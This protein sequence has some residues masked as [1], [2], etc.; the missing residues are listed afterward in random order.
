[1]KNMKGQS[2]ALQIET[3]FLTLEVWLVVEGSYH[4]MLNDQD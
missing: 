4:G 2:L 1:M 3:Q